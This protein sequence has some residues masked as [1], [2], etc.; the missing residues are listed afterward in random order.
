MLLKTDLQCMETTQ[1]YVDGFKCGARL[2]MEI[3]SKD[4][5]K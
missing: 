5:E 2:M 1:G 4:E 3:L